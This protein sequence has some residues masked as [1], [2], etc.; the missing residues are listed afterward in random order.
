MLLRELVRAPPS[1]GV[2]G[3]ETALLRPGVVVGRFE[4]V[5]EVGRGGFGVVYEAL[6]RELGRTVA[7]KA[8]RAGERLDLREE[9]LM[10]EAEAAARCSHP[11]IVTLHD[12][13]RS[14]HGPYLVLEFLQGVT[15]ARR[16]EAG[17]LPVREALRVAVEVAR[18]LA[19]AHAH[20][21][22]H[23]DLT[24]GN[25]FVCHDGRV[26]VLD[27]GMAHAF[28]R[29]RAA[30]GTPAYMAPEQVAG[31]PED[32]RTDVFALGVVLYRMLTG[33]LPFAGDGR[34][35]MGNAP[36]PQ[37]E[38]PEVPALGTLLD[39]ML[40]REAASRLRDGGAAL[41]ELER[42]AAELPRDAPLAAT[43]VALHRP[44]RR[45]T[46]HR[47]I[48]PAR[49]TVTRKAAVV[50]ALRRRPYLWLLGIA[51]AILAATL[52]VWQLQRHGRT[53][54]NPLADARFVQLTDFDGMEQAAALSRDGRF[55][56]FLSNRD[57]H[58]DVWV[59]QIGTG[60]FVNLTRGGAP[61]LVNP[62]V[63]TLG[64]SPD[65]TL[66]TY[67]A[68]GPG[69][70]SHPDISVWAT[71]LLGGPARPYL[72]G[73]AEYDWSSDGARLVYHTPGPGDPM[74]VRG[75]GG[76]ADSH[77]IFSAPPG[78][79]G[80]FIVWS[81]DQAFIYFVQGALPDR[82]DLWRIRPSGGAPERVTHHDARVSHPVFL[83]ARTV[84]YLATDP[85]GSGPWIY[86]LDVEERVPRRLS[87]GSTA[88]PLSQRA[89]TD[90]AS[91]RRW[92]ARRPRSGACRSPAGR[93]RCRPRNG[94]R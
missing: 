75:P 11:N 47:A 73:A 26:K 46:T 34:R 10:L 72:D 6:D 2:G 38:I 37:L 50:A 65:G 9:R 74:Y 8:V 22:I 39:K 53:W 41:S 68:R 56:A 88:T 77:P 79:H 36:A 64:F 27:L 76:T 17:P 51:G 25:V 18:G 89:P 83:D 15:L 93:R 59:T 84:L 44:G 48:Q 14:E 31:A 90:G 28:G 5:R 1:S 81:P 92:R 3:W 40:T 32:E 63:R 54:E 19:H 42:I 43:P 55:A 7:F 69:G 57:G 58:M 82:L 80:H 12:V 71:P 35:P 52:A 45:P 60:Q 20:G 91:W 62:S 70:S 30:G 85:D 67:W 87:S 94:S 86:G 13:G 24:P 23:R 21:V 33:T 4:L 16:L 29:P 49:S 78:L 66:V 61:E